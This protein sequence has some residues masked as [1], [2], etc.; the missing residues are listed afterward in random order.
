MKFIKENW[1]S[2]LTIL[3]LVLVGILLLVDPGTFGVVIIKVAG[4]LFTA[5]GVYDL[6]KYF[7]AD[8]EEAAKGSAF[9]SG[10]TML[11]AG[12]FC[13]FGSGWFVSVFPVLAV[14]Y[15]LFQ[16]LLG[17]RKAQRTVDDIRMKKPLWYLKAISA[18]ISLLFGLIIV[19]N[20]GM[21]FMSIWVF[22]GITLIIEG[23]FDAVASFFAAEKSVNDPAAGKKEA[24]TEKT[25]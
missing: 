23:I 18:A 6:I 22:T 8:P 13:F 10:M 9:Y 16:I 24:E 3:F 7:R 1:A 20:P 5:L 25:D 17:F 2:L 4:I 11:S 12:C 14:L 19:L 21:T 15:G